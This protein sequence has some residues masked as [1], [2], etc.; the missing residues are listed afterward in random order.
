MR[1][2]EV[3][4]IRERERVPTLN[5]LALMLLPKVLEDWSMQMTI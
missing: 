4:E 2:L 3:L 1:A 5:S